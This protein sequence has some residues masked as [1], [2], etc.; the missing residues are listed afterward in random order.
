MDMLLTTWAVTQFGA[1]EL[2]PLMKFVLE[3][4]TIVF[5][6]TKLLVGVLLASLL[7]ARKKYTILK[8][9]TYLYGF[10]VFWNV[11]QLVF[12]GFMLL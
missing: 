7:I 1:I 5:V 8:Y 4:G 2:N 10:V 6:F 9:M 12:T 3:Q 11:V